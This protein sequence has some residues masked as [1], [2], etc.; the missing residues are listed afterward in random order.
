V[1]VGLVE[2]GSCGKFGCE[3]L[4]LNGSLCM[5]VYLLVWLVKV[6]SLG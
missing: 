5:V 3:C 1:N 4:C 2:V 6:S